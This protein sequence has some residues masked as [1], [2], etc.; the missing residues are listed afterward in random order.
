MGRLAGAI[1]RVLAQSSQLLLRLYIATFSG[2]FLRFTAYSVGAVQIIQ[3]HFGEAPLR[4]RPSF[5]LNCGIEPLPG[6]SSID[7]GAGGWANL[8]V[9]SNE[10]P[11]SMVALGFCG[12]V[13]AWL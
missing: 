11:L 10:I 12:L 4:N 9:S 3:A 8:S 6:L 7:G 1:R 13:D 2:L 5:R